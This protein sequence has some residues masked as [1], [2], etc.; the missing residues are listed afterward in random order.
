MISNLM[1]IY[2]TTTTL[3]LLLIWTP[4]TGAGNWPQFR[5]TD[6]RAV[7]TGQDK[8]PADIGPNR[9]LLWKTPLAKGHSSPVVFGDRVYLTSFRNRRLL[10]LAIDRHTGKIVWEAEA[11]YKKLESIHRIGSP[12]TSSVATDGESIISFFG[13]SG[14]FCYDTAGNQ[15]WHRPLGPFNNQFGATS[16]PLLVE[17]RIVC[18]QDHDTGAFLATYDLR[19]GKQIWRVERPN[20]RRNY[21][22]PVIWT[23]DGKRQI[24]VT[25]TAHVMG[26][27]LESGELVWTVRGVCRV[28]SNTPVVGGDGN[29]YVAATG[30]GHTPPQPSFQ[31][32]LANA[33]KNGNKLLETKELPNSPI[34]GFFYQFDR[35]ANGSLDETEYESIREIYSLS[36]TVAL[37]I[38]PGGRGDITKSHVLWE[39]TKSI[40][41][42]ASPLYVNGTLF[43]AK[44]GGIVTAIDAKTGKTIKQGRLSGTGK[45]YSSPVS[46][47]GKIYVLNERGDL[48]VITAEPA[49]KQI[50]E[51]HFGEDV[52]ATPAIANGRIYIRTVKHLYCFGVR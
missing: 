6:G 4:T 8:L 33:D 14:L 7:A 22:S 37:A 29:L 26:Y 39:S 32:L 9:H 40:P 28:I 31:Q 36:K 15:R 19:T 34:R 52:Y 42:N 21:G 13:S 11:K 5:G 23:V 16:S 38:K 41:R 3:V 30:G 17:D 10:T 12:A 44:D 51:A 2:R 47:D 50:A 20:F 24:V 35:N 48:S 25:G 46:G 27:D 43:L 1:G 45:S 49:W 18:I